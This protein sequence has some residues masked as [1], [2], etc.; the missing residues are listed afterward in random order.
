VRC[1]RRNLA[2]FGAEVF[3]GDLYTALP[4][5]IRGRVDVL[6]ANVP[7]VPTDAIAMM[8]TEAREYEP[9]VALDG[10]ADGLDVFRRM[11]AAAPQ[12]LCGG[13]SVLAETSARQAGPALELLAARGLVP[14]VV[15]DD[16]LGATV[17]VGRLA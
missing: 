15:T 3:E 12:W 1:A 13:G 7:Y 9:R 16:G 5:E 17:V 11:V 8:P 14:K 6:V 2:D 4:S 10:G